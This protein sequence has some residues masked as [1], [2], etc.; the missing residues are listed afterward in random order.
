MEKSE[1]AI[2]LLGR[3]GGS[4]VATKD[5]REGL[6]LRCKGVSD[7]ESRIGGWIVSLCPDHNLKKNDHLQIRK[8]EVESD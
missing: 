2:L 3:L 5:C 4:G 1:K 8:Y 6:E 7:R